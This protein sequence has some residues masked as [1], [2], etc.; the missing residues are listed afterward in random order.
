MNLT[1]DEL[2]RKTRKEFVALKRKG[3][4]YIMVDGQ[5][6]KRAEVKRSVS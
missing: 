4:N 1:K 5:I 6:D 2:N 3:C